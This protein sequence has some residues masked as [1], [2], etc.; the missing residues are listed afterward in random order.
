MNFFVYLYLVYFVDSLLFGNLM[1]DFVCGNL[2]GD[3]LVE[4]IDG[5]YMYC[6]IDVMIDNLVEVKEVWEWFCLQICCV[7]F[8][9]FDVMWDY[10][11]FQY[12]MQFFFDL[13]LDEFVCYVE[14]QIVFILF[15]L[16]F[17][18]VNFN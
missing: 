16:L 10:F 14:W 5:I 9:I 15:D 4:I 3:Y 11:L 6:W 8:I 1:V 12:W 18:F 2:Q 13:L 17:C 7:V